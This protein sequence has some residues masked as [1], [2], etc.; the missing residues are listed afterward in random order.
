MK[1]GVIF[2]MMAMMLLTFSS[3]S[4]EVMVNKKH[5]NQGDFQTS[6]PSQ[7]S[8]ENYQMEGEMSSIPVTHSNE[9]VFGRSFNEA[10]I[11]VG[12]YW[13]NEDLRGGYLMLEANH[14]VEQRGASRNWSFLG[15]VLT[16]EPGKVN[17]YEWKKL[18]LLYQPALYQTLDNHE[19]WHLLLKPRIGYYFDRGTSEDEGLAYGGIVEVIKTFNPFNKIGLTVDSMFESRE[20]GEDG[21]IAVRPF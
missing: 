1:K 21:Y 19:T 11:T 15:G 12:G 7:M 3:V 5:Q 18:K 6:S 20:M 9:S 10:G 14:W 17:N 2:L 4:A 8:S 16:Y 13:N